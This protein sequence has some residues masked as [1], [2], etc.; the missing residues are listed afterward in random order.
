[1]N[2]DARI[3]VAGADTMIGAAI[4]RVL[5]KHG[6]RQLVNDR[7]EYVF[8][9]AGKSGGINANQKYPADLC[10]DNLRVALDLI[11]ASVGVKKLLYLGSSCIY[12]K[13]AP[14]PMKPESLWTGPLEATSAP[15]AVAKLAG[16][17]LCQ[18]YRQQHGAPFITAIPADAFGPGA[19]F[20]GD[21][22]HVV[23]SLMVKMHEAKLAGSDHVT[24]WGSGSPRREFTYADDLAEA[25]LLVMRD[26]D[27]DM[28]I[29]LGSGETLSI[30]ELAEMIRAVVGF[31]GVLRWDT[32][33]PD[34]APVKWLDTTPLRALGW[35]PSVSL[36]SGLE[37]TYRSLQ[38]S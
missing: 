24:L 32:T 5:T 36:Q 8:V 4:V 15:Y 21:D 2:F 6:Y 37:A 7:P 14:Q 38:E 11:P 10:A 3:H 22:S 29:N 34:G 16:I 31:K 26:Y 28:P 12:P 13:Q 19:K 18:S 30:R 27:G 33:R 25:C 17:A 23:P 1:M 20:I 35:K 9:T